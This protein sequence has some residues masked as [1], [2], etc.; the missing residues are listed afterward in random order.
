MT[1]ATVKS[2][3]CT[4]QARSG[5]LSTA[6][7]AII[8][9]STFGPYVAG[10]IRTEQIAVYGASLVI[11]PFTISALRTRGGLRLLIPWVLYI[12]IALLG[13]VFPSLIVARWEPGSVLAGVDNMLLPLMILMILWSVVPG[14]SASALL[15]IFARIIVVGMAVNGVLAM[16]STRVDLSGILRPFWGNA[17]SVSTTA[18]LAALL[19]RFGGIFNQPAEA[20]ALYGIAGLLAVFTLADRPGRLVLVLIPIVI[21]GLIS[22]SKIFILGG[23]PLILFYWLKSGRRRSPVVGLFSLAIVALGIVQ[24]G[25]L[26]KWIGFSYLTRLVNPTEGG[27]VS[28][29]S[30]GRTGDGSSAALIAAETLR[31][32]PLTGVGAGGWKVPYDSFFSESLAVGGIL[33]FALQLC[34]FAGIFT[35]AYQTKDPSRR[36]FTYLFAIFVA[37]AALGFSPLTANRVSTVVWLILGLLVLLRTAEP[38]RERLAGHGRGGLP[39]VQ[40]TQ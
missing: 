21:G 32:S 1:M 15:Q 24:S 2:D 31:V 9:L 8:A 3:A 30:S 6:I 35:L 25:L 37:G 5:T 36:L 39:R 22:V 26:D 12:T 14:T 33:G 23:I 20:G 16:I 38:S 29:Y 13:V 10:S 27:L 18:E 40:L 28:F 11:L 7:V 4:P 19:G 34:V 17:A